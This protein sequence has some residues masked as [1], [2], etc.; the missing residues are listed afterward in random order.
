MKIHNS[1]SRQVIEETITKCSRFCGPLR[2]PK[3]VPPKNYENILKVLQTYSNFD[4]NKNWL[5]LIADQFNGKYIDFQNDQL[6]TTYTANF[7]TRWMF[8]SMFFTILTMIFIYFLFSMSKT[9][10]NRVLKFIKFRKYYTGYTIIPVFCCIMIISITVTFGK[11]ATKAGIAIQNSKNWRETAQKR[12]RFVQEQTWDEMNCSTFFPPIDYRVLDNI[13]YGM[14]GITTEDING[15]IE[16]K[17]GKYLLNELTDLFVEA[18][19]RF[20]QFQHDVVFNEIF[21]LNDRTYELLKIPS[22]NLINTAK[23]TIF[24][25]SMVSICFTSFICLMVFLDLK[26]KYP[27][28]I[29]CIQLFSPILLFFI[30]IGYFFIWYIFTSIVGSYTVFLHLTHSQIQD[31]I[32]FDRFETQQFFDSLTTH[33]I[34]SVSYKSIEQEMNS[35]YLSIFD[36]YPRKLIE[37]LMSKTISNPDPTHPDYPH[38]HFFSRC[39]K[40]ETLCTWKPS[41]LFAKLPKWIVLRSLIEPDF[42]VPAI[43]YLRYLSFFQQNTFVPIAGLVWNILALP[44]LIFF[45]LMFIHFATPLI[46]RKSEDSSTDGFM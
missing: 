8:F 26:N 39:L 34:I 10:T 21:L 12:S 9:L 1:Y 16:Y 29:K 43:S 42:R 4:L 40:N 23:Y 24:V 7:K 11:E 3:K 19:L 44:A 32:Y 36:I 41:D 46:R 18:L 17:L 25:V 27:Q 38:Y 5:K 30:I 22:E 6:M 31:D 45:N 14:F 37:E 28:I 15:A 13:E 2:I 20:Y 33:N 35:T